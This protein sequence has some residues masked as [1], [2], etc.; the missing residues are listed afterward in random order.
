MSRW[1]LIHPAAQSIAI[2][3]GEKDSFP[4]HIAVTK[5]LCED[6]PQ[7]VLK[8]FDELELIN[9]TMTASLGLGCLKTGKKE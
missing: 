2:L 1:Y 6:L 7:V 9:I 5:I 4:L 8:Q 3:K